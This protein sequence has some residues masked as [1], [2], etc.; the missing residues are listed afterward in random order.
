[1][2]SR[3]TGKGYVW[4]SVPA[5]MED[6]REGVIVVTLHG[7]GVMVVVPPFAVRDLSRTESSLQGIQHRTSLS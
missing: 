4:I 2:I 5:A 3:L 6:N 1:L 7:R